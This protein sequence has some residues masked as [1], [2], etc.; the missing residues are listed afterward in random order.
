MIDTKASRLFLEFIREKQLI[1]SDEKVLLAVSGG[2]DSV[3]MARLFKD[4]NFTFDIAHI[5]FRLRGTESD[6]DEVFVRELAAAL[7][8]RFF[9]KSLDT[10]QYASDHKISVEMAARDLRNEWLG[11]LKNEE[12][13]QSVAL[14]HHKSDHLE[15]VLLNLTKGTSIRGLRGI[16]PVSG[17]YIRPMLFA[18]REEIVE[19]ATSLGLK[20]RTDS[21][22]SDIKFQRNLIRK[23]VV[24]VLKK[25]NPSIEGS[26]FENTYYLS[27][28]EKFMNSELKSLY[29]QIVRIDGEITMINKN[30][31]IS[32]GASELLLFEILKPL[33]FN[34]RMIRRINL[35]LNSE[36]GRIFSSPDFD[37]LIDR[38]DLFLTKKS[39]ISI[40]NNLVIN[41]PGKYKFND[42][43]I[44]VDMILKSAVVNLKDSNVGYLDQ[45]KVEFPLT[46]RFWRFGDYFYPFG[47]NQSKKLSDYLIDEKIPLLTKRK[48]CVVESGNDI[49][50]IVGMRIDNRFGINEKT[51]KIIKISVNKYGRLYE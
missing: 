28:I 43:E 31:L 24:P 8:V 36:P 47:M 32:S 5:N 3:L 29:D 13:Y 12:K 26:V 10:R 39:E 51:N 50:W 15:T 37:L 2:A 6:E 35:N 18:T 33:M 45:S 21:T 30:A 23:E 14:G 34:S 19:Y 46:I 42:Q 27:L 20:W 4:N 1:R 16:M 9:T 40:K 22:N 38:D 48:I 11:D 25:I 49:C 44:T 41:Q 7:G 17:I